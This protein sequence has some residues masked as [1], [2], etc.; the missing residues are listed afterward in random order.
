VD[1]F[2]DERR[3]KSEEIRVKSEERTGKVIEISPPGR[4]RG[5]FF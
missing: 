5:G 2:C 1:L 3:K 4:G